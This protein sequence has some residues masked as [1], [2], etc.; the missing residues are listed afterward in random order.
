MIAELIVN[1]V[2]A[3]ISAVSYAGLFVLMFLE[4]TMI[5]L[6]SELVMPFAGFLVALEQMNLWA[7]IIFAT[8]G[9]LAGS[10][11]GYWLGRRYS[12][13]F[14]RKFGKY[15][16][17]EKEHLAKAQKYFKSHGNKTIFISRFIPGIRHVI[18][19]PAG[20]GKMNLK[21]FSVLTI[22]GAGIWNTFLLYLGYILQKNWQIVY[23]YSGYVDMI[24]IVII[25]LLLVYYVSK[26]IEKKLKN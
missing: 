9:S 21:K 13:G 15:L 2:T 3:F 11:F 19:I 8:L 6:P 4:S 16:L 5:P 22:L 20:V 7:V 18:S 12:H 23:K 17:L 14:V 24:I 25:F 10:L 1:Y 26:I